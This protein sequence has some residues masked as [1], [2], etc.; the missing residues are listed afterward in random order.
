MNKIKI[1]VVAGDGIGPEVIESGK[2]VL[3]GVANLMGDL[4]VEFTDFPYGCDYYKKTGKMMDE[5]GLDKLQNFDAIYLGAVG[6]PG[7]PDNVSLGDLLLKIRRG[8]DQYINLRPVKLL[9]GAPCPLAGVKPEDIDMIVVRENSEG[10]YA[11][12]GA[13][14]YPNSPNEIALQTGI[15]SRHGCERVMRY[16]FEIARRENKSVTSIS[17]GNALGYSMVFWDQIF[18]EVSKEYPDVETHTLLV[19]AAAMFFVK[20]PKR[21]QV[22][23]TSNLFGDIL[24]DLGAAIAG[25]MGLAAGANLNPEKKYPSMFEPIHGSAP[26]IAGKGLANPLA[27]IWSISQMLEFFGYEEWAKKIVSAIETLLVEKKTLTPDLGG[28]AKTED[29]APAILKILSN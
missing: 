18:N 7:V 9:K 25:G 15:F 5:D 11:N 14:L 13:R 2:Q 6:S 10:E 19:D 26:D 22:V 8:F 4:S 24:T 28:T 12:V 27:A 1:A 3:N 29:I 16:A 21:F 20:N 17:K 23:V